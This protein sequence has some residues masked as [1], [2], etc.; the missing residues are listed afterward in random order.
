MSYQLQ[1]ALLPLYSS[2]QVKA[3][4]RD[5][6][7]AHGGSCAE[8]M[9]LAGK[10]AVDELVLRMPLRGTV[11]IFA[12]RGNNGGDGYVAARLLAGMGYVVRLFAIGSVHPGTEAEQ[13]AAAF[14]AAGGEAEFVLPE[15]EE[16]EA[17]PPDCIIDA[18]LG[19]G[20]A[21]APR[22]PAASWI[23][24]INTLPGFKLS[25]DVPSGINA[26]TGEAPGACIR[27]DRTV[28]M[29]ALKPGLFTASGPDCAGEVVAAALGLDARACYERYIPFKG[30]GTLPCFLCH[31]ED[32]MP[33]LPVR[34]P[35][36]HKGENG[37]VLIAGGARGYAGAAMISAMAALRTG[38]G[39]IKAAVSQ[40]N[41]T[42]LNA[43]CP[44]VMS[45]ELDDEEDFAR[46]LKWAD[47]AAVG[48]GL[49]QSTTALARVQT[50]LN[51]DR[52]VVFDADALNLIAEHGLETRSS[53]ERVMTPHPGEAARLLHCSTAE[54]NADRMRSAEKLQQRYGGV[55]LL[56]GAGTVI[57][58]GSMVVI[59]DEGS[60]SMAS[61]GMG[62][63]LTG[64]I[65][66]LRAQGLPLMQAVVCAAAVHG[67][68]GTKAARDGLI[69]T[70]ATDL[71]PCIRRLIN[72]Y[73]L[74]Q[75]N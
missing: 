13:A 60:A 3:L 51:W 33:A 14:A 42:A 30:E 18:L 74:L 46:A 32:I 16:V 36:C 5:Y 28:C 71:L 61:G 29:L 39:L 68:A 23:N 21:S 57:C 69:G 22:E 20:L 52:P 40:C 50:A 67:R 8:L 63:A 17:C 48:P 24:Y 4:E 12:G 58:D 9:E 41:I 72:G 49:G 1:S 73:S 26:D 64:V 44:E 70:A 53:A 2:A 19:T 34:R 10:A 37:R 66:A 62:D 7:A 59:I 38:A 47:V 45:A 65:A 54:I 55:V 6:A 56:K 27:A 75:E 31:Y 25:I 15:P 35:A 11:W 43:R